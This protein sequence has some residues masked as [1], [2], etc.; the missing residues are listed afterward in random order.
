VPGLF[1]GEDQ[2]AV[3]EHVQHPAAAEAKL[4][5]FY[6]GLSFQLAFQA[7]GLMANVGSKD[8]AL[9]LDLHTHHPC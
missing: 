9:D 1:L 3:G 7:P 4:Y 2:F 5:F 6:S 8:T